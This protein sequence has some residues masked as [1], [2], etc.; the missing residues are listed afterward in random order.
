MFM[1]MGESCSVDMPFRFVYG[2]LDGSIDNEM[3]YISPSQAIPSKKD[4]FEISIQHTAEVDR[5]RLYSLPDVGRRASPE[6]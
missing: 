6:A 4:E 2:N 3:L 1:A 5:N